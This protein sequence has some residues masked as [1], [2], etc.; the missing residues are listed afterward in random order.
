MGFSP[1]SP[2]P[3]KLDWASAHSKEKEDP[4]KHR[5]AQKTGSRFA[6]TSGWERL[7]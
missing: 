5:G 7:I 3:I 1:F 6:A 2:K 4:R